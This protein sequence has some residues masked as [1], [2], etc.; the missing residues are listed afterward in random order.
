LALYS[1]CHGFWLR[2]CAALWRAALWRAVQA[3]YAEKAGALHM[4][5]LSQLAGMAEWREPEAGM[6][7]VRLL[8][9]VC[10]G[11]RCSTATLAAVMYCLGTRALP[12]HHSLAHEQ[13]PAITAP[14][15]HPSDFAHLASACVCISM[16]VCVC[17]VGAAAG[18]G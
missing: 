3:T 9:W 12:C 7:M 17:A 5:A 18:C 14:A 11:G 8:V 10:G 16:C 6:F 13:C 4:A 1:Y 2:Q 15:A